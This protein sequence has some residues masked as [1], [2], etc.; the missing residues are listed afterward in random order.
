MVQFE[1]PET[2]VTLEDRKAFAAD[3][4]RKLR[5]RKKKITPRKDVQEII[6]DLDPALVGPLANKSPFIRMC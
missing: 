3:P 6:K 5:G 2:E 1:V 4:E